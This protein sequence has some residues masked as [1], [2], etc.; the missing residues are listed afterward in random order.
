V[1]SLLSE[2]GENVVCPGYLTPRNILPEL[3]TGAE[4]TVATGATMYAGTRDIFKLLMEQEVI[5][6]RL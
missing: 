2:N 3:T 5:F 4:A 1:L 6:I